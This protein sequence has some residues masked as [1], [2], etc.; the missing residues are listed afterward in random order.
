MKI[1]GHRIDISHEDKIF[2]PQAK[3]TKGDVVDYFRRV[4]KVM[5]PNVRERPLAMRRHPDGIKG[6]GFSKKKCLII[7]RAGSSGSPRPEKKAAK[8]I[9]WSATTQRRLSILPTRHASPRMSG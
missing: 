6:Q 8:L 1:G 9:M 7:F 5:L 4:A 2:F 3:I